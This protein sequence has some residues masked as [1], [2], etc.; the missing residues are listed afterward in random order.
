MRKTINLSALRLTRLSGIIIALCFLMGCQ[1]VTSKDGSTVKN[2]AQNQDWALIRTGVSPE[3]H[4]QAVEE[5]EK[6]KAEVEQLK[7]DGSLSATAKRVL[8][9]AEEAQEQ[10]NSELYIAKIQEYRQILNDEPL[11]RAAEAWELEARVL[12]S[13]LRLEEAQQAIEAAVK[14]DD[15]NPEYLLTLADYL[16]WNGNY[17]RMEKVSLQAVSIIA[18][19]QHTNEKLLSVARLFL[20]LAYLYGGKHNLAQNSLQQSLE[21]N[22]K[23]LGEEHPSVA[24]S[25]NNFAGLYES[26]G[27]Y[28]VAEP[29]FIQALEMNKKLLGEEHPH[30]AS[31][32]NN[33]PKISR[34]N[35]SDGS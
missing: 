30:F 22:K 9:E 7:Q 32:F 4:Q 31:S 28:E 23:L 11:K 26:L 24:S 14:L 27:I 17:Q 33:D 18:K 6:A 10:G 2:S 8:A 20:G 16:R 15:D 1:T 12:F 13:Q 25:L 34:R 19:E 29:L 35:S 3:L 5:G 21:M